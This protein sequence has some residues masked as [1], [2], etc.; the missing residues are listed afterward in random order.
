[1]LRE[2]DKLDQEDPVYVVLHKYT[3]AL[4]SALGY[5]DTLTRLH[6]ERVLCL[7]TEIGLGRGLRGAELGLL[8]I[9]AAF[10]DIGK[11]GIPDRILL[12]TSPLDEAEW[13]MMKQ[14]SEMGQRILAATEIE[15]AQAASLVIRHHHEHYNG[16]GYPDRLVGAQISIF[17]RIIS[18][19]DSYDA[20]AATRSYHRAKTHTEIMV[21]LQA[22]TG[23][24]HDPEL[25]R[26]FCAIIG[27]SEFRTASN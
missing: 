8:K 3:K 21:I 17:S 12:K 22:E 18:I 9:S 20:M 24:R 14:H 25:M 6:S 23:A 2:V 7:A 10:H 5:R 13:V 15:G 26:I 4:T 11:I 19:A 16:G 1:M 27:S